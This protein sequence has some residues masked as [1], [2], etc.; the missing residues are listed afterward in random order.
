M[1]GGNRVV[2]LLAPFVVT[3]QALAQDLHQPRVI[4]G[5]A[6]F[7]G[8]GHGQRLQGVQEAAGVAIGIGDQARGSG[9]IDVGHCRN[10]L[11]PGHDLRQIGFLES[12]QHIHGGA[13]QQG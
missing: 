3:A 6:L 9:S 8:R 11:R 1:Q 5:S 13:G 2:K 7:L 12:L 4:N 10:R